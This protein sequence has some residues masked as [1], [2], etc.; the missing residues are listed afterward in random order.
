[1]RY[2]IFNTGGDWDSTTLFLNGDEFPAD[3]LYISVQTVRDDFG[4]YIRGGLANGG[5]IEAYI[6]PQDPSAGQ[7]AIFPGRIDL[8][9][10]THK[11]TIEN[12]SPQFAIELTSIVLDGQEVSNEIAEMVVNIDAINNE[13]S[14]YLTLYRPHLIA[15][16]EVAT[17][18]LI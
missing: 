9:F 5:E 14:A 7:A 11:V 12:Q 8:E 4:N 18:T 16:D 13:V 10:P 15:A 2:F 3:Q 17:Y 1:M 6:N